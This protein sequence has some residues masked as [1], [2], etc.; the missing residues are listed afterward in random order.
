MS[1]TKKFPIWFT[2]ITV[3]YLVSN[4]FIFGI[5]S[6]IHPELPWPDLGKEAAFPIQFFAIRHIALAVPLIHGLLKKNITILRT[7]FTI[8]LVMSVL[9]IILLAVYG[10]Y[11]PVL[12]RVLGEV[13]VGATIGIAVVLFLVPIG[14]CLRYL[15]GQEIEK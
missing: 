10:Y 11:I 8:F 12:V 6:L 15:R 13:S 14:L 5:F 2:V 9:D 1:A 4:L 7:M 3:L